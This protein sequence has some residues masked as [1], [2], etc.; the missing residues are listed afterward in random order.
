[1]PDLKCVKE[2]DYMQEVEGQSF[3][4]L[5]YSAFWTVPETNC[6]TNAEL[7]KMEA[8]NSKLET[9]F[10]NQDPP[11]LDLAGHKYLHWS[12]NRHLLRD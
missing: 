6:R 4:K 9:S 12:L 11:D 3:K 10:R 2:P 8:L 1:M 5:D 7:I